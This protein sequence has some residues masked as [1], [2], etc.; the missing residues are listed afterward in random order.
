MSA[1]IDL[2]R[3]RILIV[4]DVQSNIDVLA[5]TLRDHHLLSVALDGESA[6]ASIARSPPDLVLLDLMMPRLDG[7]E[8]CRRLRASPATRD[9]PIVFLSALGEEKLCLAIGDVSGKGIPAALL[10]AVTTTLVRATARHVREPEQILAFVNQELAARGHPSAMSVKLLCAV[11][12]TRSGQL[13]WANAGHRSPVLLRSGEPPRSIADHA[14]RAL[15]IAKDSAFVRREFQLEPGD[16]L[17]LCT[18]GLAQAF[19]RDGA[20]PGDERLLFALRDGPADAKGMVER[21][22]A[23]GQEP[24]RGHTPADDVALLA[25]RW[26]PAP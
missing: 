2:T 20:D 24:A 5:E 3:C 22:L 12:D 16:A 25:L 10:M 14:G 9:L 18:E 4:D 23:G 19:N 26:R 15:A 1:P 6:L 7:Y 13:A 17:F 21:A 8:V 11:L